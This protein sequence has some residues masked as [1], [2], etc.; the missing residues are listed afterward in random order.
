MIVVDA[1]KGFETFCIRLQNGDIGPHFRWMSASARRQFVDHPD[2]LL[3]GD[4]RP[5]G[6]LDR[7]RLPKRIMDV[8]GLRRFVGIPFHLDA[9]LHA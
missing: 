1:F 6:G 8:R 9:S 3:S 7:V 5:K 4:P 2:V